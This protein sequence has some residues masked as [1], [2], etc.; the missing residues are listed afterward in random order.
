MNCFTPIHI[1]PSTLIL[2]SY[3]LPAEKRQL[4]K[5]QQ[6][7]PGIF[8]LPNMRNVAGQLCSLD[9]PWGPEGSTDRAANPVWITLRRDGPSPLPV[10]GAQPGRPADRFSCVCIHSQGQTRVQKIRVA[11][12]LVN[13]SQPPQYT[14]R[15]ET[16]HCNTD[17]QK[18]FAELLLKYAAGSTC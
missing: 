18:Q 9:S 3:V 10:E 16:P 14:H 13:R 5:T 2:E 1:L 8:T 12:R 11:A 7:K 6:S 17:T 15:V 4:P